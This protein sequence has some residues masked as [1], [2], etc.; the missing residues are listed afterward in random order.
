MLP[1]HTERPCPV[2]PWPFGLIASLDV[3][4]F[5]HDLH[6]DHTASTVRRIIATLIALLDF[7]VDHRWIE[8]NPVRIQLTWATTRTGT[9]RR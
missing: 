2:T 9:R 4:S 6:A 7:A 3:Q 1:I 8:T 5:A